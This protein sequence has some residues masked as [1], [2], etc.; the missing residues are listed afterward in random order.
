[1]VSPEGD[2]NALVVNGV[3]GHS[4]PSSRTRLKMLAYWA[5]GCVGVGF[6][7]NVALY[8]RPGTKIL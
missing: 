3:N 2:Q 8:G 5:V 4:M 6:S 1:M 7:M